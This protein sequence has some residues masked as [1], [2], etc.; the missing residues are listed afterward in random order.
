VSRTKDRAYLRNRN[1]IRNDDVCWLCG[2]WIDP[3][4]S[5]PHPLS[6]SADHVI[7]VTRGG[8]NR[9]GELKPAH[10]LCNQKRYN[11]APSN[12]SKHGRQW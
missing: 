7:P 8:D 4:Y 3:Q 12:T 11:K 1:R 5:S 2:Q 6:W 10:R 9:N